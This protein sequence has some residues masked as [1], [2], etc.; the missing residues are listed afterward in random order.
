M[1]EKRKDAFKRTTEKDAIE[2][3]KEKS[4]RVRSGV[5]DDDHLMII[6]MH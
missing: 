4:H 6:T 2:V 1:A 5:V 3:S